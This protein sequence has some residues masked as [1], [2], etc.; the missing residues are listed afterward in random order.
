M[1]S[2]G[3]IYKLAKKLQSLSDPEFNII[4]KSVKMD[5]I[6]QKIR[7]NL[8]RA[9]LR[10][11]KTY[12]TRCRQVKFVPGQ[13]VYRR[14]FQQSDFK[15]NFN[16]KLAKKFLKCRIVRPVG[17]SLYEVEDLQGKSLG[18]FHAKDLKQ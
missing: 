9:Y 16:A 1:V 5:L 3:S 2:H 6:R 8:H 11:E 12:N 18:V 4:P 7:E 14:N 17:N 10:N 13:E 15:T